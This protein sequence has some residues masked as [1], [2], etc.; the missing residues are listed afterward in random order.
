MANVS[1]ATVSHVV[2]G[3]RYVSPNLVKRVNDVIDSL[4]E[5][6][7]FVARKKTKNKTILKHILI[8]SQGFEDTFSENLRSEIATR[9]RSDQ[10]I[11]SSIYYSNINELK[12]LMIDTN[13]MFSN[14]IFAQI[15]IIDNKTSS[16]SYVS[17]NI[18]TLVINKNE[19]FKS[20]YNMVTANH[21][22]GIFSAT[23][24]LIKHGHKTI[25]YVEKSTDLDFK[26]SSQQGYI[27]AMSYNNL[28]SYFYQIKNP[29]NNEDDLNSEF[30][31]I[32]FHKIQPSAVIIDTQLLLPFLAFMRKEKL[33]YPDN[34]SL[35]AT[36]NVEWLKQFSPSITCI[37]YGEANIID[38]VKQLFNNEIEDINLKAEVKLLVNSS[39]KG[40][41]IGPFGEKAASIHSLKL[42][43]NQIEILA[44]KRRTAVISFHYTGAS[45][46]TL[47]E[48]GIRDIFSQLN[49]DI[50][51]IADAHF[52]AN[53]QNKQLESFLS[54]EPD[55]FIA[56]PTDNHKTSAMFKRIAKSNTK[57]ILI[58]N[59]PEGLTPNDYVSVISVNEHH[60]GR[61]VAEGLGENLKSLGKKNI[62]FFYHDSNFYATTQRDASA[63]QMLIEEFP[64][65]NI[66]HE[67]PFKSETE[68]YKLTL[69]LLLMYP[70]INGIYVPWDGPAKQV[71][72]ALKKMN[73]KD[74]IVSTADLDYS[75]AL[76]MAYGGNI[77]SISA[78]QP[79]EQGR[80]IGLAAANAI[81]NGQVPSY[82]G[83]DPINV[84]K[85]NLLKIWEKIY[86]E[87]PPKE[88]QEV[89]K[90]S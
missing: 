14:K 37:D 22:K 9:Y 76:D 59:V 33:T 8:F 36:N 21:K 35:V 46:M 45:W 75:L 7:N 49:I 73:R 87:I 40:I 13:K 70:Q 61:L 83:I 26:T 57:L 89:Y 72:K 62:G 52:D 68:I 30:H 42:S 66:A 12:N 88:L 28:K 63:K 27:E 19:A 78:Q 17:K 54:F 44:S 38:N 31:N 80:A 56:I 34:I 6:P 86:K 85:D 90:D 74:I 79:Y 39:T 53:L 65:L 5:T 29:L 23:S 16:L 15:I 4:D 41:G 32:I 2:N 58:T 81:L 24:H 3:T 48:K 51:G 20:G 18:T 47:H 64:E 1:I 50:I 84:N 60:H 67:I 43:T 71:L 11:I 77:R 69:D 55:I 10:I 25:A 82:I